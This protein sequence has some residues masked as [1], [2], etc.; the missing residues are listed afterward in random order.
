MNG[1]SYN[2]KKFEQI[3]GSLYRTVFKSDGVWVQV[4]ADKSNN[5]LLFMTSNTE[6]IT[7]F[8]SDKSDVTGDFVKI[9]RQVLYIIPFMVNQ[10]K[11]TTIT[12][13]S[14]PHTKK[15]YDALFNQ[16]VSNKFGFELVTK[17][18]DSQNNSVY[19]FKKR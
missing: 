19:T 2:N 12:V 4:V 10:L 15:I 9:L 5:E 6:D 17:T 14:K 18:T 13:I 16:R 11:M 8:N 7:S 3:R 1:E